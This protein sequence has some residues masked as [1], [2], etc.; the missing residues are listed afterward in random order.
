MSIITTLTGLFGFALLVLGL[1]QLHRP[2]QTAKM[3]GMMWLLFA[4]TAGNVSVS[5]FILEI[6]LNSHSV[7]KQWVSLGIMIGSALFFMFLALTMLMRVEVA[8][9]MELA[10]TAR[11]TRPTEG[12]WPPPPNGP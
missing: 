4:I 9:Q 8:K 12:A 2:S 11:T 10:E 6:N 1:L 7:H 5:V 3:S